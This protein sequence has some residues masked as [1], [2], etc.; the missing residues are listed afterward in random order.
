MLK[1]HSDR[2]FRDS[3]GFTELQEM[4]KICME[5]PDDREKEEQSWLRRLHG[6]RPIVD[7]S[8]TSSPS[9]N[10]SDSSVADD[11]T[12]RQGTREQDIVNIEVEI[13]GGIRPEPLKRKTTLILYTLSIRTY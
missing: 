2:T 7:M 4:A 13:L 1:I 5:I 11:Y 12:G 8:R 10:S 6:C 9:N 3:I